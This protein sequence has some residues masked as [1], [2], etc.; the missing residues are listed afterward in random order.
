MSV[1][2]EGKRTH[3]SLSGWGRQQGLHGGPATV[4]KKAQRCRR[5]GAAKGQRKAPP[6]GKNDHAEKVLQ[7]LPDAWISDMAGLEFTGNLKG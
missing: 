7:T 3:P 2:T 5:L 4:V 1:S 6:F